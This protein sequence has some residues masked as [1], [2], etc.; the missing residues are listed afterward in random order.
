[1]AAKQQKTVVSKA[2][3]TWLTIYPVYINKKKTQPEG[4]RIA[5]EKALE[6]PACQEIADACRDLGFQTEIEPEKAY[7]RDF[8]LK[9]RVRV[10]FKNEE[11]GEPLVPTIKRKKDLLLQVAEI[12]V[13]NRSSRSGGG[14]GGA[15]NSGKKK[16]R[17]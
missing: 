2:G 5:V 9:G 10:R 12:L 8:T 17:R 7:S 3:K 4:R 6:N 14:G 15:Q 1:M 13:R 16:G 11:D